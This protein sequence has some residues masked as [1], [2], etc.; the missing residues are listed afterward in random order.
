MGE[1]NAEKK[2]EVT[3]LRYLNENDLKYF[4]SCRILTIEKFIDGQIDYNNP[5]GDLFRSDSKFLDAKLLVNNFREEVNKAFEAIN[6][7][8]GVILLK[9]NSR[10]EGYG[11]KARLEKK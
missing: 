1:I 11:F 8:V 4:M 3:Q 5:G 10:H 7:Q 6:N 2:G 9:Q